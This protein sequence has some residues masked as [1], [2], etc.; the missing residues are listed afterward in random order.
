LLERVRRL[1]NITE[2]VCMNH[3]IR[4]GKKERI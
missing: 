1:L 2:R 3:F 4:L